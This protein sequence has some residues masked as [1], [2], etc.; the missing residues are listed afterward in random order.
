M[1]PTRKRQIYGPYFDGQSERYADPL[2]VLRRLRSLLGGDPGPALSRFHEDPE[3]EETVLAAARDALGMAGFDPRTGSGA[4][5]ADVESVLRDFLDY[6]EKNA[7][8]AGSFP[9]SSLPTP[10]SPPSSSPPASV[11]WTS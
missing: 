7:E 3:A 8:G 4:T 6:V 9:T 11:T 10:A 5:D 2:A 1:F